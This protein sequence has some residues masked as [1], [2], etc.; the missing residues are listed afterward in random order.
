MGS[1]LNKPVTD[2]KVQTFEF[3]GK[4]GALVDM[5]GWRITM[6]VGQRILVVGV[7]C[8]CD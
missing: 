2:K 6:E 4:S 3:E 5:Q 8:S 1:I 7:G